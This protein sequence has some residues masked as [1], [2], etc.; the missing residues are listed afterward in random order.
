M[1]L[2]TISEHMKGNTVIGNS[3]CEFTKGKSCMT[4]PTAF[5]DEMTSLVDEEKAVDTV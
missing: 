5:C 3:H 2:E 1:L 4:N